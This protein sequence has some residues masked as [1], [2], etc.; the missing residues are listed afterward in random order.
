MKKILS[1][2]AAI[3]LAML[4]AL[5]ITACAENTNKNGG[6]VPSFDTAEE[7]YG[8]SAAS[9]GTLISSM[10]GGSALQTAAAKSLAL[11][12]EV[13]DAETIDELNRYMA[14]VE[15][16]LADG[17]FQ[18]REERSDREGYAVKMTVSYRDLAGE[19]FEYAL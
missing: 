12:G 8:F 3:T 14:L 1:A 9:A 4:L 16:L 13:T 5:G 15:S 11:Q 6:S 7:I 2:L 17:G 18:M 10:N 19:Q